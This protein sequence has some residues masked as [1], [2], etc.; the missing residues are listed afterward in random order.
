[1]YTSRG[2][3]EW[4]IGDIDVVRRGRNYHLFH[5]VLP[6]HDYIAHAVSQDGMT[7]TRTRNAIFTGEP[8]SWDDDMLWTMHV[9][10]HPE[11]KVYEMF[12]TGL[13]RAENGYF[14]R[15][16]RAVSRDLMA[17][18]KENEKNLPLLPTG[19]HYEGPGTSERGWVS[20]RD[21]FL[22]RDQEQEWL[23]L[24]ARVVDG[25]VSRR[26]CVGLVRRTSEGYQVE[27]PL[28]YPRMY[29]DIECPCL[30]EL[31]GTYYLI[32]S[33]RE[34]LAVHYWCCDTFRGEYR[35]FNHN[36]LLPK[37]NYAARAMRDGPRTLLYTFYIDGSDVATGTRSLPPPKEL[38]RRDDGRLELVSFH[39]WAEKLCG[40]SLF[41]QEDL[42]PVLGN[43]SASFES[44]G[45]QLR[46]KCRS[47][48]EL[49]TFPLETGSWI[50]EMEW[51]TLQQGDCGL[52]FDLDGLLNGY[53]VSL[54]TV[55]GTALIRAWG[56]RLERVFQ[57]Y[58]FEN[59]Q[60]GDFTPIADR[61]YAL[62]LIRWGGYVELSV[63]GVVRLSLVDARF[64]GRTLGI[65]LE[66][67]EITLAS[68]TL[69]PLEKAGQDPA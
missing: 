27:P 68:M 20:F 34:D 9:T 46:L 18:R 22:W 52:V 58:I 51:Q 7:W 64:S 37:G 11:R 59:L 36:V 6:N 24:C 10:F 19:L 33:I 56:N 13:H 5:L 69:R 30:V 1:M 16:G 21:P 63:N 26:G 35:A 17:W 62:K 57:N 66:S 55:R 43:P 2:F 25:P 60:G 61:R 38:R 39:R 23:L 14:Q 48:F 15:I 3:R 41:R 53:F 67:A 42:R 31:E 44:E 8:G 12:Y 49:F 28:F 50:W 32:G 45:G 54:D 4:E 29:D 40:P 65:Y 47:G